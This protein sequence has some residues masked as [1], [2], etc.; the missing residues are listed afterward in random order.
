V[1]KKYEWPRYRYVCHVTMFQLN[2]QGVIVADRS[3]K[4]AETDNY[5]VCL[6]QK[7]DSVL[8]MTFYG[9]FQE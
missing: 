6:F 8:I 3:L 1:K 7:K 4:F 2:K 9:I 5:A